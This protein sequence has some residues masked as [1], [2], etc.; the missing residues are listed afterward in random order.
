MYTYMYI[1]SPRFSQK[2]LLSRKGTI[3]GD[4]KQYIAKFEV[5]E[6][7]KTRAMTVD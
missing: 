3:L 5:N 2:V 1:V 6:L 4:L 7:H